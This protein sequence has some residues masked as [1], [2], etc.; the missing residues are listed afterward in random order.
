MKV[1]GRR[2]N[3]VRRTMALKAVLEVALQVALQVA[4]MVYGLAFCPRASS[5]MHFC[6]NEFS[7]R[8][9]SGLA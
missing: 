1:K 5:A 4:V 6:K 3:R 8:R 2:N 7:E 9:S